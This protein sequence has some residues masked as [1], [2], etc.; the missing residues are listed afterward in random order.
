[1]KT[2]ILLVLTVAGVASTMAMKTAPAPH[3]IVIDASSGEETWESILNNVTN[4][5][6]EFSGDASEIQVVVHGKAL[7][8]LLRDGRYAGRVQDLANAGAVFVA[9]AN[10]MRR[11][12]VERNELLPVAGVVPSGLAELVRKQEAGWS[13][14]K[15]G[16]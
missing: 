12:K 11:Q 3:R 1:M 7:G 16:S 4:L 15:A 8:L 9:C 14:V 6:K 2:L 10:T 5:Q 13:Y